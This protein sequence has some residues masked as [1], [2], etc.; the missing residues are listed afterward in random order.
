MKE[1]NIMYNKIFKSLIA[2]IFITALIFTAALAAEVPGDE[3]KLEEA[4]KQIIK[5]NPKLLYDTINQYVAEQQKK[6][7]TEQFEAGFKNRVK[8]SIAAANPVKGAE[9]APVTII[10]YSD[11]QCSY[12]ARGADSVSRL[13]KIYPE[14]VKLAFKNLPLSFHKQALPAAKAALAAHKQGKFWEYHDILFKNS[15][16]LNEKLFLKAAQDLELDME[17]FNTDRKS[18]EISDQIKAEQAQAAK[19]GITGTPAFIAN[20]VIIK[21]AQQVNYFVK[22]VNRLLEEEQKKSDKK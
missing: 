10:E 12:C 9:N 22:V 11:F 5:N 3:T 7:Q 17:K 21:G 2:S 8:D 18:P 16:T 14:K 4:V 1:R 6:K 19:N 20:G 15:N 13:L